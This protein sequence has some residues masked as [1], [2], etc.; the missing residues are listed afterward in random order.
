MPDVDSGKGVIRIEFT[1]A[2]VGLDTHPQ[3]HTSLVAVREM[4][5]Q[6]VTEHAVTSE[7]QYA[8]ERTSLKAVIRARNPS[9]PDRLIRSFNQRR[10]LRYL[11]M[12]F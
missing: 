7:N 4:V 10:L 2:R 1:E 3:G 8:Q 11:A 9:P 6:S 5:P 12:A